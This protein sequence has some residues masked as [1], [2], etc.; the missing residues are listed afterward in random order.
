MVPNSYIKAILLSLAFMF[1]SIPLLWSGTGDTIRVV[2]HDQTIVVTDPAKGVK[3]Y[4]RGQCSLQKT[5][6]YGG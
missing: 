5:Y 6:R 1:C 2:S 4:R 3:A